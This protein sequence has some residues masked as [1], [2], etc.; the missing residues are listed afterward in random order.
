MHALIRP[1]ALLDG[2]AMQATVSD[3][4]SILAAVSG[5]ADSVALLTGLNQY[6]RL[7]K[8]RLF[9][10]HINHGL[11]TE[12]DSDE[13]FVKRLCD[14]LAVPLR[15]RHIAASSKPP[16]KSP[17]Q[18]WR[19]LRY[20][21]FKSV[22]VET[23]AQFLALG[24]T[25][26]DLA[27]TFLFH[28][29][30]GTGV[31]GLIFNFF[32][33]SADLPIIRPLWR[34][35]RSQIE[36]TLL[37]AN[38]RWKTDVTNEDLRYSRNLIRHKVIPVLQQLNPFVVESIVGVS[39]HLCELKGRTDGNCAGG[40]RNDTGEA[41]MLSL[42]H[43]KARSD[44]P[45]KIRQFV[46]AQTGTIMDRRQTMQAVNIINTGTGTV[47]LSRKQTLIIT[48]ENA[49]V[50]PGAQPEDSQLAEYHVSKFGGLFA[51][52][53]TDAHAVVAP[54]IVAAIDG[55]EWSIEWNQPRLFVLRNP[56]EGDRIGAKRL[57]RLLVTHKIPW[58]L[59]AYAVLLVEDESN[60]KAVAG[61]EAL[62]AWLARHLDTGLSVTCTKS[63]VSA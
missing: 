25:A 39:E 57:A 49:W 47:A 38:Q 29:V 51:D 62:N 17:E 23:N 2:E 24:H 48:Q 27:E 9:A 37:H 15:V 40:T 18:H 42:R 3:G 56:I 30:R 36:Q 55:T 35:K 6:A 32:S 11:R 53:S 4:A 50:Y 21:E 46:N 1:E 20:A 45:Q 33:T 16:Q 7:H 26:D 58:Y 52:L 28:L 12:A 13:A 34:T 63:G 60:I 14:S 31:K 8:I 54:V 41:D 22:M 10:V 43:L 59:R 61:A 5:G 19:Q 44:L